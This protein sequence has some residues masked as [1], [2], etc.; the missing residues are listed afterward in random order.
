MLTSTWYWSSNEECQLGVWVL[1]YL[2]TTWQCTV[3]D[4]LWCF[5]CCTLVTSN[6]LQ[7]LLLWASDSSI[8]WSMKTLAIDCYIFDNQW[9]PIRMTSVN[10]LLG[11][12]SDRAK[13]PKLITPPHHQMLSFQSL[14]VSVC[15]DNLATILCKDGQS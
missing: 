7:R 14:G 13:Q 10:V 6:I 4:V 5:R 2:V 3:C 1:I 9:F 11:R 12:A 15:S 8:V